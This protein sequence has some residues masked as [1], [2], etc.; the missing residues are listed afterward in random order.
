MLSKL[1]SHRP[2]HATVVA[3]L[4]LFVALGGS[5]YAAIRVTGKN[6]KD[7]SLTAKDIKKSSLTTTEVKDHSL[8]GKDLKASVLGGLYTAAQ[9]DLRFVNKVP[10]TTNEAPNSATLEGHP[11]RDFAVK[12]T[13]FTGAIHGDAGAVAANS[14][15][16]ADLEAG[17]AQVGDLPVLAFV[18]GTPAPAGLVFQLLKVTSPDHINIRFCNPTNTP[19]PAFTDVGVR[20]ITFR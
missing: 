10:G 2:S 8:L 12:G 16:T 3:Y 9:S 18:G 20:V 6:V 11:A 4:A 7:R 1:R 15:T 19:S 5:S 13:D 14:C 17:G